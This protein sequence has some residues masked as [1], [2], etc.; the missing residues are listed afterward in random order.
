MASER[1][2]SSLQG[3]TPRTAY[4]AFPGTAH[5]RKSVYTACAYFVKY[6][7]HL[8]PQTP[9]VPPPDSSPRCKGTPHTGVEERPSAT[10]SPAGFRECA[11]FGTVREGTMR[12]LTEYPRRPPARPAF[13]IRPPAARGTRHRDADSR[14]TRGTGRRNGV[15]ACYPAGG[16]TRPPHRH[17][18]PRCGRCL[19]RRKTPSVYLCAVVNER[20][21]AGVTTP[22]AVA[23]P[24]RR[25]TFESCFW[26]PNA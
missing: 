26:G 19:D 17:C 14:G 21:A 12:E 7:T 5:F 1:R 20:A 18:R 13:P 3:A 11:V 10:V 4:A 25:E 23:C 16:R 2:N 8:P 9:P 15:S 6:F 22:A 24:C